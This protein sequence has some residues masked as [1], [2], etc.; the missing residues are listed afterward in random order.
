MIGIGAPLPAADRG[1]TPSERS[2]PA[3]EDAPACEVAVGVASTL[4][5][6]GVEATGDPAPPAG[7][8]G[9]DG[10]SADWVGGGVWAGGVWAGGVWTGGVWTGGVAAGG[11]T[12]ATDVPGD[13]EP[14]ADGLEVGGV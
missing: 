11:D 13:G 3:V 1:G 12:S 5:V 8:W 9:E 10:G 4:A 14:W 2:D 6:D 7:G